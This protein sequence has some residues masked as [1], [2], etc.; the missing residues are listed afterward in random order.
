MS[1]VGWEQHRKMRKCPASARGR[2]PGQWHLEMICCEGGKW[3]LRR[4]LF[5]EFSHL[6]DICVDWRVAEQWGGLES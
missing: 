6:Q 1:F 5:S 2:R 3:E 4:A